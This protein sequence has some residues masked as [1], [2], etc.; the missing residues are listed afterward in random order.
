[1]STQ[2]T[3]RQ[4]LKALVRGERLARPLLMPLVFSLGSRLENLGLR[5]FLANPT[6]IANALRQIH[7]ALK[8]DGL[9][10]YCDP[11]LEAE[12][13]SCNVEWKEDGSR[14]LV[15]ARPESMGSLRRRVEA[16]GGILEM[17]RIPVAT[18]VLRRLKTMLKDEPA[19]MVVASGP[20]H[21]AQRLQAG[22]PDSDG[23]EFTGELVAAVVK[24]YLEAGADIVFL[25]ERNM[26]S[27]NANE[28]WRNALDPIV[29]AI[30][31]YEAL[32]VLLVAGG[33][34]ADFQRGQTW[35]C[36]L[37]LNSEEH[38]AGDWRAIA[39]WWGVRIRSEELIGEGGAGPLL[40]ALSTNGAS[41]LSCDDPPREAEWKHLIQTLKA[42][43][44]RLLSA[45]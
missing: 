24:G 36:A 38:S 28:A 40:A 22:E 37:C 32:P 18:E 6:K 7:G 2:Q 19:L 31:F 34:G 17:G 43:R 35:E 4:M 33:N 15:V 21:L 13:L 3:S 45:V 11:W 42:I 10:C 20:Y 14:T 27:Q 26:P 9:A 39:P 23:I 29:N 5:D 41:F 44:D 8:V 25:E 30:R 1:M 12:A 16:A